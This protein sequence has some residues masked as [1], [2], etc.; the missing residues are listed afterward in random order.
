MEAKGKYSQEFNKVKLLFD[1]NI[2]LSIVPI[3]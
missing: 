1:E 2:L 3:L